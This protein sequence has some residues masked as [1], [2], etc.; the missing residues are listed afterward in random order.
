LGNAFNCYPSINYDPAT[1]TLSVWFVPSGNR[2]ISTTCRRKL[3]RHS[4]RPGQKAGF[5]T[6]SFATGIATIWSSRARRDETRCLVVRNSSGKGTHALA[7]SSRPA[8][9]SLRRR[10]TGLI[11]AGGRLRRRV[12]GF[13]S[14]V[15][16]LLWVGS[17]L[18]VLP[19]V[20][21]A[22]LLQPARAR[23][24]TSADKND[25]LFNDNPVMAN[26]SLLL[27]NGGW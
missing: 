25:S 1:R 5:S 27:D 10:R 19:C 18:L 4:A 13:W 17:V 9:P 22:S 3:M 21:S 14:T 16:V 11:A 6:P 2:T 7:E 24:A 15:L 8:D 12:L 20:G 23:A 26:R